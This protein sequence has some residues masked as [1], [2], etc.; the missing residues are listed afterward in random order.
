MR[1]CSY[2]P[3]MLCL[4]LKNSIQPMQIRGFGPPVWMLFV[5]V[6]QQAKGNLPAFLDSV[7]ELADRSAAGAVVA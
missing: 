6:G 1:S 4:G 2:S 7:R 5:D 3:H